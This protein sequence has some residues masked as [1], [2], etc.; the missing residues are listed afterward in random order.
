MVYEFTLKFRIP[1]IDYKVEEIVECLGDFCNDAVVGI[2]EPGRLALNFTRTS[3][4]AKPAILGA[5][6]DV[7][8]AVRKATLIEITPD[9]VSLADI[10]EHIGVSRQKMR[11]LLLAHPNSFPAPVHEGITAIWH[12]VS[13]LSWL[14]GR[15]GYR[16]RRSLFDVAQ[17]AM[18]IN[19][20]R[21]RKQFERRQHR[22][23]IE[24]VE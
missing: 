9:F 2:G 18:Q 14:K 23:V 11:K 15:D 24:S 5:L 20:T 21:G 16:I 13:V 1:T 8:N 19:I 10:A 7:E 12:L 17:T 3:N 6:T 22:A 4:S